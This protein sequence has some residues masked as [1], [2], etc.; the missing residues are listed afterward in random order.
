M[1]QW[2]KYVLTILL[3]V[4]C[5]HLTAKTYILCVGIQNYPGTEND[6]FLCAKDA[7]TMQWLFGKNGD[8][9]SLLL[10]NKQATSKNILA[11]FSSLAAKC[12]PSDALAIFYCGHGTPGALYTYD[13]ELDYRLLWN[14]FKK[15]QACHKF[16]FINACFSGTMRKEY[17]SDN[18]NN[19]DVM[20]F[21]SSRSNESSLEIT[22]MKNGLFTA[23]L[24]QGLRGAAD[25]D[26][27]RTITARELFN[28]VSRMV[29]EKSDNQQHPVMWGKFNDDMP[30]MVWK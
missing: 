20:F 30:V 10:T 15:S 11:S 21:M 25:T 12:G 24:Q 14:I 5:T 18:L 16:A 2:D 17:N 27:N 26:L 6:L 3:S 9:E 8:A 1:A 13:C 4:V 22:T 23:Y 29:A 19:Q 28:Y 7:R